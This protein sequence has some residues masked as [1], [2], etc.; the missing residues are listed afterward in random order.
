MLS[1]LFS[2]EAG[3]TSAPL[4][5]I[6][7]TVSHIHDVLVISLLAD[8]TCCK[9]TLTF[10]Y[11]HAERRKETLACKTVALSLRKL[12]II[13]LKKNKQASKVGFKYVEWSIVELDLSLKQFP[14]VITKE[15]HERG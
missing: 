3:T 6:F 2:I 7:V 13:T 8:S 15:I 9:C 12:T 10:V 1:L 5:G 11:D 14:H 4:C